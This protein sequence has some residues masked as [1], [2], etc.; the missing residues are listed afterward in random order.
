MLTFKFNDYGKAAI[1]RIR[2]IAPGGRIGYPTNGDYSLDFGFDEERKTRLLIESDSLVQE[3]R[4]K[5]HA[6]RSQLPTLEGDADQILAESG[7]YETAEVADKY[8]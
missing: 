5:F 4:S 6:R 2:E 1:R 8:R 3:Y 7:Y